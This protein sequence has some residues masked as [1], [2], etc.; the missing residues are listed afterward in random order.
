MCKGFLMFLSVYDILNLMTWKTI[1][2]YV[3]RIWMF[4]ATILLY[5][6]R[7]VLSPIASDWIVLTVDINYS[8]FT[9]VF[10]LRIFTLFSS[11]ASLDT[12][13]YPWQYHIND[14]ISNAPIDYSYIYY[15]IQI[16]TSVSI[17][18][19]ISDW[20]IAQLALVT[21]PL[22][23][24]FVHVYNY[25]AMVSIMICLNEIISSSTCLRATHS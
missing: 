3:N 10:T 22:Y 25:G 16:Y 6:L 18:N 21:Y 12:S 24:T 23:C 1:G 19:R 4:V 7:C 5:I 2:T 15:V 11:F 8:W 14:H 17:T 20:L 9:R 13:Y